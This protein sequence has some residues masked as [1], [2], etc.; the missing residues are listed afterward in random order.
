M[1]TKFHINPQTGE[2]GVCVANAGKCLY[3][4]P[5][6]AHF[7]TKEA[8]RAAFE[9]QMESNYFP[10]YMKKV[11]SKEELKTLKMSAIESLSGKN[12]PQ[13]RHEEEI[14]KK[15][16][17][18]YHAER[19]TAIEAKLEAKRIKL[20]TAKV[21]RDE[22]G[23]LYVRADVSWGKNQK[24]FFGDLTPID[25]AQ[26]LHELDPSKEFQDGA[27]GFLSDYL[28][29]NV[30]A[31]SRVGEIRYVEE[32]DDPVYG[33]ITSLEGHAFVEL[34]T[35]IVVDSMG[36][37]SKDKFAKGYAK[38]G[39]TIRYSSNYPSAER[40]KDDNPNVVATEQLGSTIKG[41][42]GSI[43]QNPA[44]VNPLWDSLL[45]QPREEAREEPKKG[46]FKRLFS[47]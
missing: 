29:G 40:Y 28:G 34:K 32:I 18:R 2:P 41:M 37:W 42:V 20:A 22:N 45:P 31:V 17:D 6:D 13:R 35:G 43:N 27:C 26:K 30:D 25:F 11:N 21:Q 36:F 8:A 47:G 1:V 3:G 15:D 16:R 44:A 39:T 14:L 19:K 24:I 12:L 9:K 38:S 33:K 4:A 23:D 10:A 5:A 46:F 7:F